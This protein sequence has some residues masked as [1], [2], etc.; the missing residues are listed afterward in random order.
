MASAAGYALL[1][2][3]KSAGAATQLGEEESAGRAA[4]LWSNSGATAAA[5]IEVPASRRESMAKRIGQSSFGFRRH[6][7]LGLGN[8]GCVLPGT[9]VRVWNVSFQK[10]KN[11]NF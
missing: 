9:F 11:Q 7:L 10:T 4:N 8:G 6:R 3:A 1:G 2:D 5:S